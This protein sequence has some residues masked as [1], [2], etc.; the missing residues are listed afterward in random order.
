MIYDLKSMRLPAA[1]AYRQ[2]SGNG[3]SAASS[4]GYSPLPS[5]F[6]R[7]NL[8]A[9]NGS[10]EPAF[11]AYDKHYRRQAS[12]GLFSMP[13]G[14]TW[15]RLLRWTVGL[16]ALIAFI[17]WWFFELHIEIALYSRG[18][19]RSAIVDLHPL[20]SNCFTLAN[21][22]GSAYN[23]TI[24]SAP[25]YHELQ[26]GLAMRYGSDCYDFAGTI[27]SEPLPG[28]ILPEQTIYHTY[29]RGDLRPLGERQILLLLSIL[30]TQSQDHSTLILWSN[31]P[32]TFE[33]SLLTP[34]MRKYSHR[35]DTRVIDHESLARGTPMQGSS[36]LGE[37]KDAKA[38]LDGDLV[39][40]LVLYRFGGVWVDMDMLMTRDLRPLLE[41]E[42][43]TQWDCYGK[44]CVAQ[45]PHGA[46]DCDAAA[47]KP[48]QPLNG[49]VMHFLQQSPYLCEMLHI[50]AND[51]PPRA[52]S[53]DWGSLMYHKLW[54]RL[55]ANN[56]RPFKI[57]P[58]C[59]TDGRSC[60][61]DNRLPDPFA[62][63]PP[64]TDSQWTELARRLDRVFGVHLHN[65]WEK[66]F[67]LRGWVRRL[68]TDSIQTRAGTDL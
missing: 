59:F 25:K 18:W 40:V 28:Q 53:T 14:W 51:V 58:F 63:D 24:A 20:S 12:S 43:V 34:L 8:S 22:Q 36:L 55:V 39:R 33:S 9:S 67:P 32:Q 65:Q 61:L 68:I 1:T 38:W 23:Q 35:L 2:P 4:T 42:W 30:E 54:R 29:W 66:D 13:P 26:A 10:D 57:L 44:S 45:A 7:A 52:A 27:A 48:Y 11:D 17:F 60:R 15:A 47:E 49:A 56:H 31:T 41:S 50:M 64:Y 6:S 37:A 21:V 3:A 62:S 19:V 5:F 16:A 46:E